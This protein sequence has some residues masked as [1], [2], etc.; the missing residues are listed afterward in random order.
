MDDVV[1]IFVIDWRDPAKLKIS[2][3]PTRDE[4][5]ANCPTE[6]GAAIVGSEDELKELN[7]ETLVAIYNHIR[8]AGKPVEA[9][10]KPDEAVARIWNLLQAPRDLAMGEK[11]NA[12]PAA[13]KEVSDNMATSTKKV[14]KAKAP[15]APKAAKAPKVAKAKKAK[16]PRAKSTK[17]RVL[18]KGGV[19][20]LKLLVLKRPAITNEE[21]KS[22]LKDDGIKM[23][24]ASIA[25]FRQDFVHSLRVLKEKGFD[26]PVPAG[27][28]E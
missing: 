1:K 12:Q 28:A 22:K 14:R 9:F 6:G 7:S 24:D 15:K 16:A 18:K 25:T 17:L 4:A 10:D 5:T 21:I 20:N 3:Y 13:T 27:A 8:R 19:Y 23:S 2:D 26:V 11:E